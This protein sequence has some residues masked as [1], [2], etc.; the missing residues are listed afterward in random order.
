MGKYGL[1]SLHLYLNIM[2]RISCFN[3]Y[4]QESIRIYRLD[5]YCTIIFEFKKDMRE[6][7]RLLLDSKGRIGYIEDQRVEGKIRRVSKLF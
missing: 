2:V 6:N 1:A 4:L 7:Q 5:N 3:L